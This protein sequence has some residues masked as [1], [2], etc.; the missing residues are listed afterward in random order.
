MDCA[1]LWSLCTSDF[2]KGLVLTVLTAVL[3][4]IYDSVQ[5]GS[6]NF[7][8]RMIATTAITAGAAYLLK[9][10]ATGTGGKLLSNEP[11]LP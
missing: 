9:N 10:L 4:I 8:W 1:K 11:K 6:L 7:N 5:Q 3:T 2:I